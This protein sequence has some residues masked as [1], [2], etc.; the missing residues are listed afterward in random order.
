MY[1]HRYLKYI[2]MCIHINIYLQIV[3]ISITITGNSQDFHGNNLEK[4]TNKVVSQH[5]MNNYL[6]Q[7]VP[8][9][10]LNN[11]SVHC[12]IRVL[13]FRFIDPTTKRNGWN[14]CAVTVGLTFIKLIISTVIQLI[15]YYFQYHQHL[16]FRT[17]L[18]NT[19]V[20]SLVC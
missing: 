10:S 7:G 6:L 20:T 18:L 1:L 15:F 13:Y 5:F 2:Y 17:V 14:A 16:N 19:E 11:L 8:T 4:P 3:C 12:F 9:L